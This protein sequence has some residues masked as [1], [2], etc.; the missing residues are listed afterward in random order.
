MGLTVISVGCVNYL[1][2]RNPNA[3]TERF[4]NQTASRELEE[5]HPDPKDRQPRYPMYGK[6]PPREYS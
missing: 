3:Y 5:R 2:R 6:V 1:F 4:T